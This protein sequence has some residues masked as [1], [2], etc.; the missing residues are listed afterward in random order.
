MCA[1]VIDQGP[2]EP[3]AQKHGATIEAGAAPTK[4]FS[5]HHASFAHHLRRRRPGAVCEDPRELL[6]SL[7]D[8]LDI[9]DEA[10]RP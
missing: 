5:L 3:A 7:A 6:C 9:P 4:Y 8:L 1:S 2:P 10:R